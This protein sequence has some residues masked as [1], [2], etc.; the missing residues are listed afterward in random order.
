MCTCIN[1]ALY[2][3]SEIDRTYRNLS[4]RSVCLNS[5]DQIDR[6]A[7]KNRDTTFAMPNLE[8]HRCGRNVDVA[9]LNICTEFFFLQC[10]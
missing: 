6:A 10:K 1:W 5:R 3:S 8:R 2:V 9:S 4:F 7:N